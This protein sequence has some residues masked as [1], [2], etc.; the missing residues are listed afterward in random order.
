MENG[1][2]ERLQ[3]REK[4]GKREKR[5]VGAVRG[6]RSKTETLLLKEIADELIIKVREK[7][8]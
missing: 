8:D 1:G 6:M 7:E 2:K 5:G 4:D 3:T